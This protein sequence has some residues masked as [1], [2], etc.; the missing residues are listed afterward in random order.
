MELIGK[1]RYLEKFNINSGALI[2]GDPCYSPDT[3][4]LGDCFDVLDGTWAA[5][6]L[7]AD[8]S[9][10]G[11]GD[12]NTALFAFNLD[13]IEANHEIDDIDVIRFVNGA[14]RNEFI[15]EYTVGLLGVDSGQAGI[16]DHK[17]YLTVKASSEEESWY[18]QNGD[19]TLTNDMAGVLPDKKGCVSS[20]GFGDGMYEYF[21]YHNEQGETVAVLIVFIEEEETVSEEE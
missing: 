9:E 18:W 3:W 21:C 13:Y 19:I 5:K 16:Y 7:E 20:S 14:Y 15:L 12:R 1:E 4:C 10:T 2:I 17:H 8:G 6:I 11:L